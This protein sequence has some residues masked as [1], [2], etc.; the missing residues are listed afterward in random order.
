MVMKTKKFVGQNSKPKPGDCC[1]TVLDSYPADA[2]NTIL[3]RLGH[4][5]GF[6]P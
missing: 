5:Q 3:G 2:Y 6:P 1:N 4:Q